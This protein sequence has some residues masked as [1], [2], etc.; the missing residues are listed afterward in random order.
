MDQRL[1]PTRQGEKSSKE[2]LKK[3]VSRLASVIDL[4]YPWPEQN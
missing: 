3:I 2:E 4:Q 1:E